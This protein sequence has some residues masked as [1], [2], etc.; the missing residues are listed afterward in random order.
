MRKIRERDTEHIRN[1]FRHTT[2]SFAEMVW[3]CVKVCDIEVHRLFKNG[4]D[5][6]PPR[7][8]ILK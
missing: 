6:S 2:G 3:P 7:I 1:Y 8:S 5:K 4:L